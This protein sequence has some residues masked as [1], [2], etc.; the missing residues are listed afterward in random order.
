MLWTSTTHR[1]TVLRR[2][3]TPLLV[4][5]PSYAERVRCDVSCRCHA[6]TW[7][8]I[9][10]YTQHGAKHYPRELWLFNSSLNKENGWKCPL[11]QDP[12]YPAYHTCTISCVCQLFLPF[13]VSILTRASVCSCLNLQNT[14]NTINAVAGSMA[15]HHMRHS[16]I[17]SSQ[18]GLHSNALPCFS[19]GP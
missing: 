9:L 1:I 4:F 12:C 17:H 19:L 8:S 15:A 10:R 13:P 16:W 18:H 7:N 11:N 3:Y 5:V 14:L 2:V 6:V